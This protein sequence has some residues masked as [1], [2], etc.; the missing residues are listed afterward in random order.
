MST[1]VELEARI[2]R[3]EE[4][5]MSAGMPY[6]DKNC[7]C[8]GRLYMPKHYDSVRCSSCLGCIIPI[9]SKDFWERLEVMVVH[10]KINAK[11]AG[12]KGVREPA[13]PE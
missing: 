13:P 7:Y 4:A 2:R 5:L 10:H 3:L 8:C 11:I 1:F 9:G 12:L 6:Q